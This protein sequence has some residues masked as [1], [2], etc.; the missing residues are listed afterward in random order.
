MPD[1]IDW[2]GLAILAI[3]LAWGLEMSIG[4]R[5]LRFLRDV[6]PANSGPRVSIIAAARDEERHIDRAVRSMRAQTYADLE[7]IVVDDRS[8]DRT[9]EILAAIDGVRVAR[10][11]AL[12]PGWLG[13]CHALDAGARAATGEILLFTDADVVMDPTLVARAV[14]FLDERRID[15]LVLTPDVTMPS[16]PLRCFGAAFLIFF[17]MFVRPWRAR[18]PR[19]RF[20][21]G[22]G[23][24]NMIRAG[25]YRAIGGHEPIRLRPDDDVK[26][27]KLVKQH[28]FAQE[29]AFGRG[30]LD[31][32]WY[33]SWRALRDGLMKNMFSGVDYRLS[34]VAAGTA[35]MFLLY[36]WPFAALAASPAIYG[37]A[38][39]AMLLFS[40]DAVGFS[41]LRRAHALA[42]PLATLAFIYLQWRA[43]I[44]NLAQ[45]GITWR[46]TRY[47]L[48]ELRA[49]RV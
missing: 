3:H 24:F 41:N 10:V 40:A 20:H 19:S 43:T 25:A 28:G 31:V 48:K 29:L 4:N 35:M 13:K 45:G 8:T 11:D 39:A 17:S 42:M 34:M 44:L 37:V 7:V 9:P 1:A 23:A 6:E 21:A 32:E 15:H 36:I 5:S 33:P 47:S 26:L 18:N 49:N 12:P 16:P 27:G 14:R 46:G 22:I 2:L 30:L 38:A